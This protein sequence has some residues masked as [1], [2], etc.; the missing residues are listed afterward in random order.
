[1]INFN[2]NTNHTDPCSNVHNLYLKVM[3]VL[4]YTST[5]VDI[6]EG[7]AVSNEIFSL[8]FNF[9]K[10][11][12]STV[13]ESG[14]IT[15]DDIVLDINNMDILSTIFNYLETIYPSITYVAPE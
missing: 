1:M 10:Y 15:I 4:I 12:D 6:A 13:L 14:K 3:D 2:L 8:A 7:M 5:S 11:Y 9:Q